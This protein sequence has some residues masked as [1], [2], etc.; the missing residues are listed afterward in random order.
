MTGFSNLKLTFTL[1]SIGAASYFLLLP[2]TAYA[3]APSSV[4]V[5][6]GVGRSEYRTFS[7]SRAAF[8]GTKTLT[9]TKT[10]LASSTTGGSNAGFY[11]DDEWHPHDPA[12]TTPQL[13]SSIW[14]QISNGISMVKGVSTKQY[15]RCKR[16]G[17]GRQQLILYIA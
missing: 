10:Q 8:V 11:T 9:T 12:E 7:A 2:L 3:F 17:K 13:L 4:P 15:N 14:C 5:G 6:A 16:Y 1:W